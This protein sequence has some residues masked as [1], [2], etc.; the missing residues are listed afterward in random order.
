MNWRSREA[1]WPAKLS[2]KVKEPVFQINEVS[3]DFGRKPILCGLNLQI[4][5]GEKFVIRGKSGI[6]KSSILRL[7]LG[8]LQPDHGEV[9][10]RGEPLT[11]EVT[12]AMRKELAY[13]NQG[14]DFGSSTVAEA[15]TAMCRLRGSG[16]LPRES[17][18]VDALDRFELDSATLSQK[19]GFL[20]GGERQRVALAAAI[21]LDRKIFL[22]DEPSAALDES[23]TKLVADF[24][25][26]TEPTWTVVVV[27]HD[28]AWFQPDRATVL[29]L[30][31]NGQKGAE[32]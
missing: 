15:L 30:G 1:E 5:S 14:L 2:Q 28:D 4:A 24:F 7:L 26:K 19:T 17:E 13:V 20:S 16:A 9:L 18:L 12:W 11:P 3:L 23:Q 31:N 32:L 10:Y 6:G 25:L 22:L 29:S 8:F 21:L 27:S